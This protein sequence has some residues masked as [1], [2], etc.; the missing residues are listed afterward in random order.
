[1]PVVNENFDAKKVVLSGSN[2]IEASAGTGKTHSIALLVLRLIIEKG[3][4]IDKILLVTF[5]RDA[6][7]E[8][9]L[10]VRSFIRRALNILRGETGET[11]ESIV[12]VVQK[13]E[14]EVAQR[15]LNAAL[16]MFDK[17][18]IFTIHGFCSRILREYA[19]ESDRIFNTETMH[20][21]EFDELQI[22]RAHV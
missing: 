22:G 10:R 14:S 7:A 17:A 8:M 13:I 11:D 21:A 19:F 12:K 5:T 9:K 16:L 4:T 1:M 15:R 3:I 20:P 18:A 6:A 2:L